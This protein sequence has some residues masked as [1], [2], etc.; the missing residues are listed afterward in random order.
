M[1]KSLSNGKFQLTHFAVWQILL[2]MTLSEYL[3]HHQT[4]A[5]RFA[6]TL[7]VPA[8]TITRLLKMERRPGIELV[9]RIESATDGI[10]SRHELRPDIYG[11]R[12]TAEAEK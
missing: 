8:S 10:V 3:A 12:P 9:A 1:A 2:T 6:K 4:S 5:S 11:P 7:Q